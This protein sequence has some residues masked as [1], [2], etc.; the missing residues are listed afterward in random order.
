MVVLGQ[1]APGCVCRPQTGH[2]ARRG[3]LSFRPLGLQVAT[4][5]SIALYQQQTRVPRQLR[6]I[7]KT[8]TAN[9]S[10]STKV[11]AAAAQ[12]QF[13]DKLSGTGAGG[14]LPSM[15]VVCSSALQLQHLNQGA[16]RVCQLGK[17]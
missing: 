17:H 3:T 13:S 12:Q 10:H 11:Q 1:F 15:Q 6:C 5:P 7:S 8:R 4:C 14:A 9:R 16:C 2:A